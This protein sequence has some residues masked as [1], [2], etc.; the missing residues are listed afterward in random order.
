MKFR[1]D[2]VWYKDSFCRASYAGMPCCRDGLV[3]LK[4]FLIY[5]K[6]GSFSFVFIGLLETMNLISFAGILV[7]QITS[8]I[9]TTQQPKFHRSLLNSC[10]L[11]S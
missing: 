10:S 7:T 8:A 11:L 4:P 9:L 5:Q 3:E 6:T 2:S 1:S